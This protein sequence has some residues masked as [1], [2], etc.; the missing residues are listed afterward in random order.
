MSIDGLLT[1][2][3][4]IVVVY[5][6]IPRSVRMR[7]RLTLGWPNFLFLILV[8]LLVHYLVFYPS[9]PREWIIV[10][11]PTRPWLLEPPKVAYIVVVLV[12]L[13]YV[14]H[15]RFRLIPIRRISRLRDLFD[16]LFA[17]DRYIQ[18][19]DL[20][21]RNLN[22]LVKIRNQDFTI[23]RFRAKIL[24]SI[25]PQLSDEELAQILDAIP[26]DNNQSR[27]PSRRFGHRLRAMVLSMRVRIS[28]M[29]LVF[30]PS[31][32]HQVET[33]KELFQRIYL[34]K[35]MVRKLAAT[36][37]YYGL[38]FLDV[39]VYERNKF[40]FEFISSLMSYPNSILFFEI[41]NNQNISDDTGY[42]LPEANR[43]LYFLFEDVRVA[44]RL[45]VW[46]PVGGHVIKF[47]NELALNPDTDPYNQWMAGFNDEGKWDSPLFVGIR[48]FDIMVRA[49]LFQGVEWHMSLYYYSHITERIIRNYKPHPFHSS[50]RVEWPTH[51]AYLLYEMIGALTGWIKAAECCP[52]DQANVVL[53][54]VDGEHQND[55]IPKS[56]IIV[57]SQCI[58]FIL[59]SG[60]VSETF[61]QYLIDIVFQL[62]FD[63]RASERMADYSKVLLI[64]LRYRYSMDRDPD[65]Q[66]IEQLGIFFRSFDKVPC[67]KEHLKEFE[68]MLFG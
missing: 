53:E 6:V 4:L 35:S 64:T 44:E 14:L 30:L 10:F 33:A 40:A 45:A 16:E 31:Y 12:F 26:A 68:R 20:F 61:K 52:V 56:S 49:A 11:W 58:R 15:V 62:Y 17:E 21:K 24:A 28:K 66:F 5:T 29:I 43:L 13:Y 65:R 1:L 67:S 9:L 2:A 7:F 19:F 55:N 36:K 41:E 39:E 18:A 63:L 59:E 48:F 57:L 54:A 23:L 34:N 25:Q 22:R 46:G 51:Y 38:T 32:S 47:L 27:G 42:W 60:D 8:I 50:D 37:P 3:A